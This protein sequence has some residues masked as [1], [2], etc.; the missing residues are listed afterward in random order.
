V[1]IWYLTFPDMEPKS[2]VV[3]DGAEI[4]SLAFS[5]NGKILA[6]G[7]ESGNVVLYDMQKE[8]EIRTLTSHA[9]RVTDIEFS[10]NDKLMVTT[11][12]DGTANIWNIDNLNDLPTILN[13][14]D[15]WVWGA[16]FSPDNEHLVTASKDSYV[17]VWP[18]KPD[19]YAS[20]IC[21]SPKVTRNM[22]DNEWA[23]YVG[24]DLTYEITCDQY[25]KPEEN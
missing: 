11:S 16:S 9:A 23:Q 7:D 20:R 3:K 12:T 19:E 24:E 1:L 14:H 13:D 22:T 10:N 25:G 8:E 6:F 15:D 18:T 5:P 17:R 2:I 21:G 4:F